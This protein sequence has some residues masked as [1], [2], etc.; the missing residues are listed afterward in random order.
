MAGSR[1]MTGAAQQ[2]GEAAKIETHP[3]S[4]LEF[5]FD[6]RYSVSPSDFIA[7]VPAWWSI[8]RAQH[9]LAKDRL[10]LPVEAKGSLHHAIGWNEPRIW[11]NWILANTGITAAGKV[12]KSGAQVTKSVAGFEIHKFVV[13]SRDAFLFPVDYTLRVIPFTLEPIKAP[14]PTSELPLSDLEQNLLIELKRRF[15]PTN[16][17]NPGIWGFM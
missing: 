7:R 4:S 3:H 5:N 10:R 16:K 8:D 2:I 11:R 6:D 15:D 13:G 14:D 17:L 9:E 1:N 12:V